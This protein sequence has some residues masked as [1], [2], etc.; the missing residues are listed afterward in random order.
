MN[1]CIFGSVLFCFVFSHLYIVDDLVL[2]I[3]SA[4]WFLVRIPMELNFFGFYL[5]HF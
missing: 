3:E 2:N 5:K 4:N 1:A